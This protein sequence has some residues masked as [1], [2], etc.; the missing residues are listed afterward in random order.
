MERR[1][2]PLTRP[3][4]GASERVGAAGRR[5]LCSLTAMLLVIAAGCGQ[6]ASSGPRSDGT[7]EATEFTDIAGHPAE[8]QILEGLRRGL[9]RVPVDGLYGPDDPAT[10]GDILPALWNASGRPGGTEADEVRDA[11][12]WAAKEGYLDRI[13]SGKSIVLDD[14]ITRQDAMELL[15]VHHGSVSGVEAMLT[16][17][18]DDG[19]HDSAQI[20]AEGKRALYWGF[21]NVLIK[22]TEPD[23]IDPSGAVSKGDLAEIMIRYMD[24]FMGGSAEKQEGGDMQ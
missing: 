23:M 10:W 24:D 17:I 6:S 21:Y 13:H 9:W 18:Y 5:L 7:A 8:E 11:V 12:S 19:F 22:E 15:Y 4:R 14:P 2:P 16:G 20:P 3:G 1:I